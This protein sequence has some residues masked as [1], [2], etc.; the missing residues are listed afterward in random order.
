MDQNIPQGWDGGHSHRLTDMQWAFS[1]CTCK[2]KQIALVLQTIHLN[3]MCLL[4]KMETGYVNE[5][6][7]SPGEGSKGEQGHA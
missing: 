7:S 2:E 4:D 1:V 6:K 3:Y 5:N